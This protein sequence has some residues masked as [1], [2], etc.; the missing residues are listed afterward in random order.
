M[1]PT[2]QKKKKKKK[3]KSIDCGQFLALTCHQTEKQVFFFRLIK[4]KQ[5]F[6]NLEK[7]ETKLVTKKTKTKKTTTF[8]ETLRLYV[9]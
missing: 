9:G 4:I 7:N 6:K 5:D 1:I 2:Y 3:K 8:S